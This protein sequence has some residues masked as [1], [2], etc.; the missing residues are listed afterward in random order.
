MAL[1]PAERA[2]SLGSPALA[3]KHALLMAV[4][5]KYRRLRSSM[6]IALERGRTPEIDYLNGELVR[7]GAAH[8]VPTPVNQRL[9]RAVM[10]IVDGRE[11]PGLD[12]LRRVYADVMSARGVDREALAA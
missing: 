7:R 8:G 10:D 6:L 5:M 4:G 12:H 2:S 11:A 9:V 3:G 1:T